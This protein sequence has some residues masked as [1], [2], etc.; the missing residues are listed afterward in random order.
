MRCGDV[1]EVSEQAY[2]HAKSTYTCFLVIIFY[3][4]SPKH[5]WNE[6]EY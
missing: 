4:N 1:A 6:S 3:L 5:Q 2:I